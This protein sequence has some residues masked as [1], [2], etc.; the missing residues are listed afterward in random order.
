MSVTRSRTAHPIAEA[1]HGRTMGAW[2]M[3]LTLVC[4]STA[5]AGLAAAGLYLHTGQEAWP[6]PELV[7]PG[8]GGAVGA[9][10]LTVF[11]ATAAWYGSWRLRHDEETRATGALASA[12]GAGAGAVAMLARDLTTA[13]FRWDEHAYASVYWTLTVTA[14]VLLAIGV[15]LLVAVVVQRL[16]GVVDARRMLEVELTAGYL[17]WCV[18]AVAVC[19]AVAHLLP[20]PSRVS[21]VA[22][23][24]PVGEATASAP[25]AGI[26][27]IAAVEGGG[28]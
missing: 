3:W 22:E 15:L 28:R 25:A 19:L 11:A 8:R 1:P 16:T 20:D 14:A 10:A 23:A 9:F 7:R 24:A 21:A 27:A 12:A 17:V 13:G 5:L 2:G 4:L 26:A 18:V 6:P